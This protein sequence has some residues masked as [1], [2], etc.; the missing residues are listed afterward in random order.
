MFASMSP[1]NQ[2]FGVI[3]LDKSTTRRQRAAEAFDKA[4]ARGLRHQRFSSLF[5]RQNRL[6]DLNEMEHLVPLGA[7]FDAGVRLVSIDAIRGSEGRDTD[8]DADFN[9]LQEHTRERWISVAVARQAGVALPPVRLVQ[10]GDVYYVR[11][12]HHRIS[13]AK[14]QGQSEIEAEVTVWRIA[15]TA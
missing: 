13:V 10:I 4:H 15:E 1:T 7:R 2:M 14:Y 6:F 5:G 3:A 12:G 8:F 9:P 11:D